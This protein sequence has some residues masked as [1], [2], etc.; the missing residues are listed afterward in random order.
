MHDQPGLGIRIQDHSET[1]FD[2][3]NPMAVLELAN[4]LPLKITFFRG[5]LYCLDLREILVT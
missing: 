2:A 4:E 5:K 1:R 3:T